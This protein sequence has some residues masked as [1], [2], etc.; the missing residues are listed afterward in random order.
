MKRAK[1]QKQEHYTKD[2]VRGI[3]KKSVNKMCILM[4]TAVVDELHIDEDAICNIATR[5]ERYVQ[6]EKNHL[7][8]MNQVSEILKKNTGIDWRW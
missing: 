4:I 6:Y 1:K 3:C 5:M 8:E 7:I 2:Q